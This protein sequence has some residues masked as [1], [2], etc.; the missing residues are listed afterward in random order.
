MKLKKGNEY[1]KKTFVGSSDFEFIENEK[2][3]RINNITFISSLGRVL[4]LNSNGYF[5]E[6]HPF[7]TKTG[8]LQV[9]FLSNDLKPRTDLIAYMVLRNFVGGYYKQRRINYINGNKSDCR[10]CNLEWRDGFQNG[11]DYYYLKNLNDK[12]LEL[13]DLCVKNY[14][15]KK[16]EWILM[17]Y[18]E[19]SR[20]FFQKILYEDFKNIVEIDVLIDEIY[21]RAIKDIKLG[22]FIPL[23]KFSRKYEKRDKDRFLLFLRVK[24][25]DFLY[26]YKKPTKKNY[27]KENFNTDM[28]FITDYDLYYNNL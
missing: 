22:K 7:K 26:H 21:L 11:I 12:K 19:N 24:C 4:M 6:R 2:Y 1:L 10:L 25:L 17:E 3:K 8:T 5:K 16:E 15:L 18:I 13:G 20:S 9:S 27:L 14:L 23:S 28:E